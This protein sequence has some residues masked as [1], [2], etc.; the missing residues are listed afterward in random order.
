VRAVIRGGGPSTR[1]A[2]D[3]ETLVSSARIRISSRAKSAC[4]RRKIKRQLIIVLALVW[5]VKS[6][7][8]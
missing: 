7:L 1:C 8:K 3:G 5:L 6:H 4:E 2:H